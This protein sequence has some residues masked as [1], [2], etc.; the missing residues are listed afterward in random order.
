MKVVLQ[1]MP[2][3]TPLIPVLARVGQ[4]FGDISYIVAPCSR[5][6]YFKIVLQ[7]TP[8]PTP[9]VYCLA[10]VGQ[11]NF[12]TIVSLH[13]PH[14]RGLHTGGSLTA[15]HANAT[16]LQAHSHRPARTNPIDRTLTVNGV[17]F[18]NLQKHALVSQRIIP[19]RIVIVMLMRRRSQ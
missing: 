16:P 9:M 3:P 18:G 15:R 17:G 2:H 13:S 4:H 5:I 8:H 14:R 10:L 11:H 1:T 19:I 7:A 6:V 12:L